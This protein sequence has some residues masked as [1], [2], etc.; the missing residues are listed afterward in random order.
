MNTVI[1]AKTL[2]ETATNAQRENAIRNEKKACEYVDNC[3]LPTLKATAEKGL[4]STIL[5]ISKEICVSL[6]V[7]YLEEELGFACERINKVEW[8]ISWYH[9][10]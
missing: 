3:I 5:V 7:K 4:L 2:F 9:A 1:T 8:R 6:A 10:E